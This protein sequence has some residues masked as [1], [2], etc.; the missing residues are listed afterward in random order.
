MV[1][2]SFMIDG[3]ERG[4]NTE[5]GMSNRAASAAAEGNYDDADMPADEQSA[6]ADEAA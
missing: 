1:E 2:H 3:Y 5:Q 4:R 6:A